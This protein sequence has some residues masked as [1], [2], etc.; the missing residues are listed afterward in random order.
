LQHDHETA[1]ASF[2]VSLKGEYK[3]DVYISSENLPTVN[4]M[5]TLN[6]G[7]AIGDGPEDDPVKP[8][9]NSTMILQQLTIK[10]PKW[11]FGVVFAVGM[12]FVL[13]AVAVSREKS[14]MNIIK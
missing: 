6:E 11:T 2:G 10:V 12:M 4:L 3:L 1:S 14:M 13:I 8:D 7:N 5:F 9:T